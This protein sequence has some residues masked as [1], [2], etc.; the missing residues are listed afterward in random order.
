[1]SIDF[2]EISMPIDL[3]KECDIRI[4]QIIHRELNSFN[5]RFLQLN[6]DKL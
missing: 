2:S 5:E 4:W 6:E 3:Q 1:M